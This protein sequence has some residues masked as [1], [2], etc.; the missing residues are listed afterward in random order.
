[1]TSSEIPMVPYFAPFSWYRC[2]LGLLLAGK[3]ESVARR[4]TN[5]KLG[6]RGKS[7][8]RT[9]ILF[10]S[11]EQLSLSIP[12]EG[13]SSALKHSAPA[14][15]IVSGH[16][17]WPRNHIGSLE[18]AYS[19]SPYYT[20]LAPGIEQILTTAPGKSLGEVA[21]ELHSMVCRML[22]VPEIIGQ[23]QESIRSTPERI[24]Q[25]SAY[26]GRL[27]ADKE[28]AFIGTLSNLGP[29]ALFPLINS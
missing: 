19:R 9:H 27:I 5:F 7:F 20:H 16:G 13:G 4:E 11:G 29:D 2:W 12:V 18:T 17:N 3:A 22:G 10:T 14:S 25:I 24:Y 28:A 23:L 21:D 6:V 26:A 8:T 15:L 1:M